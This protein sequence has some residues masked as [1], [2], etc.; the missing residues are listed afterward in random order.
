MME[1]ASIAF[2]AHTPALPAARLQTAAYRVQLDPTE[3]TIQ[4]PKRASALNVS[5]MP[6]L[7]SLKAPPA[8]PASILAPPATGAP[9]V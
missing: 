5:M 8:S 3:S 6:M 7:P 2:L 9:P 4:P 1:Q